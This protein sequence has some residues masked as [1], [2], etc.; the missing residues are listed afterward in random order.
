[1]PIYPASIFTVSSL[2]MSGWHSAMKEQLF[3]SPGVVIK[4]SVKLKQPRHLVGDFSNSSS[5]VTSGSLSSGDDT[6]IT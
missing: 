2:N 1:L 6:G 5:V 4:K 3:A